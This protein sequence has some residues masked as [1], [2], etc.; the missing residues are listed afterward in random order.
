[1]SER[2]KNR[3]SSSPPVPIPGGVHDL[4]RLLAGS[5]TAGIWHLHTLKSNSVIL[6]EPNSTRK[7]D[8]AVVIQQ[9]IVLFSAVFGSVFC[10]IRFKAAKA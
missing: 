7:S 2:K 1:M 10:V 5:E 3:I 4:Q 8:I 9:H 6:L